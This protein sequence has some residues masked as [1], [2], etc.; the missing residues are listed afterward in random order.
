MSRWWV[1]SVMP[2]PRLSFDSA[3][4]PDFR[5]HG[6]ADTRRSP[7]VEHFLTCLCYTFCSDSGQYVPLKYS[8]TPIE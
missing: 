6:R 5:L 1:P 2:G 7:C 8:F 4:E 3:M